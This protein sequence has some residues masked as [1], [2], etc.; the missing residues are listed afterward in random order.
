MT[1]LHIFLLLPRTC[2]ELARKLTKEKKE[3]VMKRIRSLKVQTVF[4]TKSRS[5]TGRLQVTG[6]RALQKSAAYTP[7][8]SRALMR[9]WKAQTGY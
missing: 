8:F 4:Y 1:A 3:K 7:A 9:A 6:T 2:A 5:K